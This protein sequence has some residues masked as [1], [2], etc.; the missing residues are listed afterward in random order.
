MRLRIYSVALEMVA[1]VA[2]LA[3]EVQKHDPDLARQMRRASTS[4]PLN[5]AEG[6]YSRG[7]NQPARFQNAM[8]S[9][10]E[11]TACVQTCIAAGY[12]RADA[13]VELLD[14]LDHTTATLWKLVHPR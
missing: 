4:V 1:L 3:R 2:R 7:G 13:Q 11:T 6:E 12:V 10:V 9:A 5:L 8:A 14:K